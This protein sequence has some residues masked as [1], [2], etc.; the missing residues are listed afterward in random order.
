[1]LIALKRKM[2]CAYLIR[3]IKIGRQGLAGKAE[4]E[5]RCI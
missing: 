4:D 5:K 1:M 2:I 3:Y